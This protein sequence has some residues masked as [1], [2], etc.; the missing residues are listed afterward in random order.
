MIALYSLCRCFATEKPMYLFIPA[1]VIVLMVYIMAGEAY[2]GG[3]NVGVLTLV[4]IM[5]L[6]TF[7]TYIVDRNARPATRE[8]VILFGAVVGI[9]TCF[10][11]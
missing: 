4:I 2:S 5:A 9:L 10:V 8:S 7:M 3:H 1:M 11:W 6:Y